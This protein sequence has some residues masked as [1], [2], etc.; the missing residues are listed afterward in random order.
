MPKEQLNI[1]NIIEIQQIK[2]ILIKDK[3]LLDIFNI[4]LKVANKQLKNDI[5]EDLIEES[6]SELDLS[7]NSSDDNI[8]DIKCL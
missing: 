4:L 1:L 2:S 5:L 6:N 3:N 8:F 7:S